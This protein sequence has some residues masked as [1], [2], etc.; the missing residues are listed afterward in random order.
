MDAARGAEGQPQE[1]T[2]RDLTARM[3]RLVALVAALN[4]LG[5]IVE[6]AIGVRIG[7]AALLADAA[8]FL[9]DVLINVLVLLASVWSL[10]AR[11]RASYVLAGLIFIPAVA[12]LGTAGWRLIVGEPPEAGQLTGTGIFALVINLVCALLLVRLRTGHGVLGRGAWLAARNDAL[13]NILII[14]AGLV[15]LAW[16]SPLPDVVAGLILCAVNASAAHEVFTEARKDN[17]ELDLD[18]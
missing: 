2:A 18:D 1:L 5:L 16:A 10:T 12:A 9:E 11:R 13:G 7:S 4:L 15:T 17:P 6:G 8:D 3:R 14:A